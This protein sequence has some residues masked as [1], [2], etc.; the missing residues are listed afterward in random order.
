[1]SILESVLTPLS[2]F[3]LATISQGGYAGVV[4]CMTIESACIPLPSEIIMPFSG[5]LAST[6]RFTLWGVALAGGIGNVFGS[7]LAY[8]AGRLGGRPL[9]E[10]LARWRIIRIADYDQG[11]RWLMRHGVAVSF[12]SRLLPIVRTFISFPAGAAR[13]PF[14]RFTLY[15]FLGSVIWALALAWVG[16]VLGVHWEEIRTYM[17]GFDLVVV[18][19]ALILLVL[20]LRHHFRPGETPTPR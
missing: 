16:M 10:R 17:R 7:W 4:A 19:V 18:A 13:V 20:W 6:G 14:G 8:A 2:K 9:A 1:M 15:T 12:W 5:Y 3:V 11:N